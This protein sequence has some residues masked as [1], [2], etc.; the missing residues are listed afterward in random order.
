M[1][2]RGAARPGIV[3]GCS[4]G[5]S[6]SG[7]EVGASLKVAKKLGELPTGEA[8][9]S[10][11]YRIRASWTE[12]SRQVPRFSGLGGECRYLC[13]LPYSSA[14]TLAAAPLRYLPIDSEVSQSR[15]ASLTLNLWGAPKNDYCITARII[16]QVPEFCTLGSINK[17]F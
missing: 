5:R 9:I 11:K 16:P 8:D 15:S 13:R 2:P 7:S 12:G 3:A 1:L 17:A 6:L 10:V 14:G 4:G